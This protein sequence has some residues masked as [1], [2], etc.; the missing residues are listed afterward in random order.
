MVS[1]FLRPRLLAVPFGAVLL[2]TA[3]PAQQRAA[4]HPP[5]LPLDVIDPM[6]GPFIVGYDLEG[7][8]TGDADGIIANAARSWM[9]GG[10]DAYTICYQPGA[11][12]R[13]VRNGFTALRL[14]AKRLKEHGAGAIVTRSG[15]QCSP[16][17]SI[18]SVA[19]PYVNIMGSVRL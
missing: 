17:W 9:I 16:D 13:A 14:V 19:P 4:M 18:Q 2:S 7:K 10:L 12:E 15:G 3:V 1:R 8:L 11:Y 5:A 6:P